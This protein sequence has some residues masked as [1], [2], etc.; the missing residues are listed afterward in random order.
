M[1]SKLSRTHLFSKTLVLTFIALTV[2]VFP[3]SAQAQSEPTSYDPAIHI[4]RE[5][6]TPQGNMHSNVVT[7]TIVLNY[8]N[9]SSA[10][11]IPLFGVTTGIQFQVVES[12]SV[13]LPQEWRDTVRS[14]NRVR[15]SSCTEDYYVD[16]YSVPRR[17]LFS[18]ALRINT[19]NLIDWHWISFRQ[20]GRLHGSY[21]CYRDVCTIS[22]CMS[23][24][25][26]EPW[27]LRLCWN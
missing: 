3:V 10:I 12:G 9:E 5:G 23:N 16:Y 27:A 1:S 8:D 26:N 21:V 6:M 15:G 25:A 11:S 19:H 17:K 7:G 14:P 2:I 24:H 13:T 18:N 20:E 4:W 22:V